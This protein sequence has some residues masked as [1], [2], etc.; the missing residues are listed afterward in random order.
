M[1]RQFPRESFIFCQVPFRLYC[2]QTEVF[3][4]FKG[5]NEGKYSKL[6]S[7]YLC[8]VCKLALSQRLILH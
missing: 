3:D 7:C 1:V 2:E 5:P 8:D 4:F 6:Y